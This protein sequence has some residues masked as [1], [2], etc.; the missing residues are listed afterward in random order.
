M[1]S[2]LTLLLFT[3]FAI[4]GFSQKLGVKSVINFEIDNFKVN[5]VEGSFSGITGSVNFDPADLEKARFDIKIDIKSIDTD[6]ETRDKDLQAEEYF[7][8]DQYPYATYISNSVQRVEDK[9]WVK[10]NLTIKGITKE[11]NIPFQL[12]YLRGGY[13]LSGPLTLDRYD[14]KVGSSSS[15]SIGR[16]AKLEIKCYLVN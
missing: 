16:E 6:N 1:K 12:S 8:S 14:F 4:S 2:L 11:V 3:T 9:F 15:I 13:L 10:G 5:T 7:N